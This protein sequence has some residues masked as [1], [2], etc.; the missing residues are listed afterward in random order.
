VHWKEKGEEKAVSTAMDTPMAH[1]GITTVTNAAGQGIRWIRRLVLMNLGLVALQALSAGF[2]LSGYGRAG[3][4]HAGVARALLLGAL[5]QAV[6]A[7]VL[8]RRRR[9]PAWVARA[10]IGLFV[11]VVLQVGAGYTKRYWLHVPIGVG[12]FGGL[13]RQTARLDTVSPEVV[14]ID[15]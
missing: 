11:I 13:I 12:L 2:F 5:G 9:V 15:T 6:A 10:G 4:I 8:W 14:S 3:T 7:A 1:S